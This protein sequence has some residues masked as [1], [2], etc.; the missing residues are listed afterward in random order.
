M[1][2]LMKDTADLYRFN[3]HALHARVADFTSEDWER[4]HGDSSSALWI[5]GHLCVYRRR[6]LRMFGEDMPAA[7]WEAAFQQG[8]KPA[9]HPADTTPDMLLREWERSGER[10]AAR[11]EALTPEEADR[12]AGFTA[13]DGSET[14]G[15]VGTF[16]LWHE[17][18]H[19]GQLGLIRKI[20]HKPPM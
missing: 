16:L 20:L 17:T 18:Y 13:P 19:I 15:S 9:E 7:D 12:P 1:K 2:S 10:L 3:S 8:T 11:L 6:V 14:L 5:V 4:Q